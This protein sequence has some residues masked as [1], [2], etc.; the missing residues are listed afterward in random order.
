MTI[1]E[2][3][4]KFPLESRVKVFDEDDGGVVYGTVIDIKEPLILVVR[5]NDLSTPCEHDK[6][7][8]K[9]IKKA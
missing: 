2:L 5:W 1:Q 4:E 8:I 7:E 9:D 6:S 3:K